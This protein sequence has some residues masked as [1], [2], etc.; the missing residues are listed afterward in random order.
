MSKENE[1][2]LDQLLNSVARQ[3][4][5][6]KDFS[7]E[8]PKTKPLF[9]MDDEPE[10]K[11][12]E[13]KPRERH[14]A[15]TSRAE[16][17]FLDE[18]E[19]ELDDLDT[20]KYISDLELQFEDELLK[21]QAQNELEDD[22]FSGLDAAMGEAPAKTSVVANQSI[23]DD[24][25]V[26]KE[27]KKEEPSLDSF[28][29][30]AQDV[31][32]EPME[33]AVAEEPLEAPMEEPMEEAIE[34]PVEETITEEPMEQGPAMPEAES[35][36]EEMGDDDILSMLSGLGDEDD[37]IADIS[38]LLKADEDNESILEGEELPEEG[39]E[40]DSQSES[41]EPSSP[42]EPEDPEEPEDQ[43][44]KK[45]GKKKKKDKKMKKEKGDGEKKGFFA[46]LKDLFF[47]P[48]EDESQAASP[49]GVVKTNNL[50][51]SDENMDILM[52]LEGGGASKEAE[53]DPKAEKKAK[54]EAKKKEA[55]E[56]KKA[57]KAE[58]EAKKKAK[59]EAKANKPKKE[60]K[61]KVKDNTPPLPKLPVFLLFVMCAS[62]C[63][64]VIL[65]SNI[66]HKKLAMK[67]AK[68][69]YA[70]GNYEAAY[71][72]LAG[73]EVK[74]EDQ[75][76]VDK[77]T[78]MASISELMNSYETMNE[79]KRYELAL[80]CLVRVIGHYDAAIDAAGE[81]GFSA[82]LSKVENK[83]EKILKKKFKLS[84]ED[85]LA[86]YKIRSRNKYSIRIYEV[87]KEVGL[88]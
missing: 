46:K 7:E 55:A 1:D 40:M 41:D 78:I 37:D 76:F 32:E 81:T 23:P 11:S 15:R 71:G 52:A 6:H 34:A 3:E 63:A 79:A 58:K 56:K 24:V 67:N 50:E 85:A 30:D 73:L 5:Q 86:I 38:K 54:K 53:K 14:R 42:Q 20:N 72:N 17:S 57:K 28:I 8:T 74:E 25:E 51:L 44:T 29:T 19:K 59:A 83:A 9:I 35:S 16:A 43:G 48:D 80:D 27:D 4:I 22:F 10:E 45:K 84:Y 13:R 39:M 82:E 69:N 62:I 64:G 60:K 18:F 87:L 88:K 47:G 26:A 31:A 68:E 66:V 36:P 21:E 2:Y 12:S 61:P 33:E 49:S 75:E 70:Q 65:T 77:V